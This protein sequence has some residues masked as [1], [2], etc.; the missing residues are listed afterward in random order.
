VT[1]TGPTPTA[2]TLEVSPDGGTLHVFQHGSA[3]ITLTAVGGPVSWSIAVS[4]QGK[5]TFSLSPSSG[6][7][8]A[9]QTATVTII[10]TPPDGETL[11]VSPGGVTFAIRPGNG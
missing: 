8:N 5:G 9:G 7:L 4:G 3:T 11:T 1:P 2:G 6:S 10:A